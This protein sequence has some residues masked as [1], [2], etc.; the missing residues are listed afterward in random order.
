[1]ELAVRVRGVW[2][3]HAGGWVKTDGGGRLASSGSY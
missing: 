1:M 3:Y 2:V